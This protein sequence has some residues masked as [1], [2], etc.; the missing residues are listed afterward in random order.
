MAPSTFHVVAIYQ[1]G[2]ISSMVGFEVLGLRFL[3]YQLL[4]SLQ[5]APSGLQV[6][7][8]QESDMGPFPICIKLFALK[9]ITPILD[10]D[11]CL[12]SGPILPSRAV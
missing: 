5:G 9:V 1:I 2:L 10:R 6:A 4:P 7:S 3:G 8:I 12:P 11:S